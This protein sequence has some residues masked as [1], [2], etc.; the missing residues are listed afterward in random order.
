MTKEYNWVILVEKPDQKRHFEKALSLKNNHTPYLSGKVEIV[1]ARGR[2]YDFEKPEVQNEQKYGRELK[3]KIQS[4]FSV[5]NDKQYRSDKDRLDNMP[6]SLAGQE[7]K[8]TSVDNS[9]MKIGDTIAN[10]FNNS[11]NII[12]ATDWDIEGELIFNDILEVY[13]LKDK[14]NWENVFRIHLT[15]LDDESI[16]QSFENKKQYLDEHGSNIPEIRKMLAQ[17]FARSII[18]YEFGYTFSFY[19]EV[20]KRQLDIQQQGGLGRLKLSVLTAILDREAEVL[21]QDTRQKYQIQ[22]VLEDNTCL[23]LD[24][25]FYSERSAEKRIDELPTALNLSVNTSKN[26]QLPPKLFNRTSYIIEMASEFPNFDWGRPLQKAYETYYCVSYPR[27]SSTYISLKQFGVLK[28]LLTNTT[29]RELLLKRLKET[30]FDDN[31]DDLFVKM[32][33]RYKFVTTNIKDIQSHHAIIPLTSTNINDMLISQMFSHS[34]KRVYDAYLEIL[35]RSIS[36]FLP[37]SVDEGQLITLKDS[38]GDIVAQKLLRQTVEMGWRYLQK[39]VVYHDTFTKLKDNEIN[40][41]YAVVQLE[42]T[43]L[44]NY[45]YPE[46]LAYLS[47]NSIGTEST[48]E[49]VIADLKRMHVIDEIDGTFVV[50]TTVKQILDVIRSEHWLS[51]IEFRDWDNEIMN[52]DDMSNALKFISKQRRLLKD[53]NKEVIKWYVSN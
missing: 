19:N 20:I 38:R 23:T 11:E 46:L 41:R 48:R 52:I 49:P 10:A 21:S 15:A 24:D 3:K 1:S 31:L 12:I 22:C 35:Y 50:N 5:S 34:D 30:G 53:L 39:G 28:Q 36:I 13:H 25:E 2:L 26:V 17:G 6:V 44:Q 43:M 40:V 33:P 47:E 16:I 45:T 51:S 29:V 14:L 8:Y 18:D 4:M 9:T 27:T 32:K 42:K 7:I 37:N